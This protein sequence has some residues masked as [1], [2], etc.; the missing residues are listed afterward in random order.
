MKVLRLE[1]PLYFGNAERFRNALIATAGRDPSIQQQARK[2]VKPDS[3]EFDEQVELIENED[4]ADQN[5]NGKI[6]NGVSNIDINKSL[7]FYLCPTT[8]FS[9]PFGSAIHKD[10]IVLILV[11]CHSLISRGFQLST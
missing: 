1:S 6:A 7:D 3:N 4:G 9:L 11:N 10:R 8:T 2:E 5:G